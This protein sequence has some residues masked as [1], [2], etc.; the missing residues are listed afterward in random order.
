MLVPHL[1]HVVNVVL[2]AIVAI[3]FGTALVEEV[4]DLMECVTRVLPMAWTMTTKG[5]NGHAGIGMAQSGR[6]VGALGGRRPDKGLGP[7]LLGDE[8]SSMEESIQKVV[9]ES[10]GGGVIR[11]TLVAWQ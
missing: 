4:D 6:L 2:E 1:I 11:Q 8:G 3:L 7:F 9:E 5:L 10:H